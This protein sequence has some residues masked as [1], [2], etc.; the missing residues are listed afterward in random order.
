MFNKK[1]FSYIIFLSKNCK[2][3]FRE[4]LFSSLV[5]CQEMVARIPL[6]ITHTE[7]KTKCSKHNRNTKPYTW[8]SPSTRDNSILAAAA[9]DALL[10]TGTAVISAVLYL[11]RYLSQ[12][13]PASR[14]CVT[15]KRIAVLFCTS[16]SGYSLV[17]TLRTSANDFDIT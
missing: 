5:Q 9:D 1:P 11:D 14:N 4:A 16:L 3:T 17:N 15:S 12:R 13:L 8:T 7:D 2:F 6:T 10:P